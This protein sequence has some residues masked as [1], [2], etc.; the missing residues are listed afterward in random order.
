[1]YLYKQ[2]FLCQIICS[3]INFFPRNLKLLL[4]IRSDKQNVGGFFFLFDIK[5]MIYTLENKIQRE[6]LNERLRSSLDSTQFRIRNKH[7]FSQI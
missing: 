2:H 6:R 3:Q 5:R 7:F 4:V 1:M